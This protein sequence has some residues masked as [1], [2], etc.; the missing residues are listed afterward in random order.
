MISQVGI[1]ISSF[2]TVWTNFAAKCCCKVFVAALLRRR[3]PVQAGFG[4]VLGLARKFIR[5]LRCAP[6][7][8]FGLVQ[9]APSWIAAMLDVQQGLVDIF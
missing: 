5:T 1:E 7:A 2:Q 4:L 8:G 6:P 9:F 3:L